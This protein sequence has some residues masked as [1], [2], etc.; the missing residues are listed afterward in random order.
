MLRQHARDGV[1]LNGRG[2][3]E[4][5]ARQVFQQPPAALMLVG[6]GLKALERLQASRA[7]DPDVLIV[8][9]TGFRSA[10]R[11]P[12]CTQPAIAICTL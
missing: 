2:R 9:A 3:L 5:G 6:Q 10:Q 11:I 4:A 1:L 8:R 12:L 7:R